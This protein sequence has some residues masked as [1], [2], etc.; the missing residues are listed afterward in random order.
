MHT[1]NLLTGVDITGSPAIISASASSSDGA[2]G[3]SGTGCDTLLFNAASQNQRPALWN[4]SSD[5]WLASMFAMPTVV[6]GRVYVPTYGSGV[7]A[8]AP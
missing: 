3:C 7:L 5:T 1:L 2:A 8:Y 4:S 6:N